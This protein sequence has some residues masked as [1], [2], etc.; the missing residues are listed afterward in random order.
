MATFAGLS[1]KSLSLVSLT[2]QNSLLTVVLHYSRQ[3]AHGKLYSAAAAVLMNELLKLTI[4]FGLAVKKS[5]SNVRISRPQAPSKTLDQRESIRTEL[6]IL[7][8]A[9]LATVGDIFKGDYW[10]LAVPALLYVV[11]NNLQYVAATH[12]DVPTFQV[13][14]NLKILTTAIFSVLLLR[15]S[16]SARKWLSLAILLAGVA[17]VQTQ[18]LETSSTS[19]TSHGINRIKGLSAVLVACITSGLAGV[20]FEMCLKSSNV[21]LWTRNCQLSLFSIPP[22]LFH[23]LSPEFSLFSSSVS[24]RFVHPVSQPLFAHFGW[25]AWAVVLVQTFG[26]LVTALVI[27]HADNVAKGF[28]TSLA[29]VL[30]FAAGIFLFSFEITPAFLIGSIWVILATYL[31]HESERGRT[32]NSSLHP[33]QPHSFVSTKIDS[34]RTSRPPPSEFGPS[35]P[36]PPRQRSPAPGSVVARKA[37]TLCEPHTPDLSVGGDSP[38]ET[39]FEPVMSFHGIV[40]QA[41]P[42]ASPP[43]L[44]PKLAPSALPEVTWVPLGSSTSTSLGHL[45]VRRMV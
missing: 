7:K 3:N 43:L 20:Y 44:S 26:G 1:L 12:L 21:D 30:S 11:Q 32:A 6:V 15:R 45:D 28:A 16:L 9:V 35:P 27:R 23:A 8:D 25:W 34:S 24:S 5:H 13:T 18:H 33:P 40:K 41:T 2:L 29:I 17:I 36:S 19:I 22:A 31:Y 38:F 39:A 10:K 42:P 37:A 14:Y 4:S